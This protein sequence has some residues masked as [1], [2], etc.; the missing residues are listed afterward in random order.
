MPDGAPGQHVENTGQPTVAVLAAMP[1]ELKPVIRRLGL[2]R[3]PTDRGPQASARYTGTIGR[4]GVVAAVTGIGTANA[5]RVAGDIFDQ[6]RGPVLQLV[7]VGVAGG[8]DPGLRIADVVVPAVALDGATGA[9]YTPEPVGAL[10][11]DGI[12]H[13]SDELVV[14]D[15]AIGELRERGVVALDMETA[16]MAAVADRHDTP[17]IAFR[18]ISD[19]HEDGL[20]DE[21]ILALTTADGGMNAPA[22]FRLVVRRP[23]ELSRLVKLARDTQQAASAAADAAIGACRALEQQLP[24]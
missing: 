17:W 11:P 5:T 21:S 15:D 22:A 14:D 12:L 2:R 1:L 16:A 6:S 10:V 4:L 23:S 19:R 24:G 20:I 13:T 9:R 8:I 7:V 3:A 18:A